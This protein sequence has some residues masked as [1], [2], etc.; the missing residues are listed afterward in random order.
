[1]SQSFI[2]KAEKQEKRYI[3][4]TLI[5][6]SGLFEID[7]PSSFIFDVNISSKFPYP[8]TSVI[9]LTVSGSP[10]EDPDG[11]VYSGQF[12]IRRNESTGIPA[13]TISGS[14]LNSFQISTIE[15]SMSVIESESSSGLDSIA[16]ITFN[17]IPISQVGA[18]YFDIT[19][20]YDDNVVPP[21]KTVIIPFLSFD[22]TNR[23]PFYSNP[24]IVSVNNNELV[25]DAG[26]IERESP[27]I[28]I[29]ENYASTRNIS[30]L[31]INFNPATDSFINLS[32]S[33][34]FNSPFRQEGIRII[35]SRI[36][37][38]P[39][40]DSDGFSTNANYNV[41]IL[42]N[43]W[44]TD[45]TVAGVI[46]RDNAQIRRLAYDIKYG[47]GSIEENDIK[48]ELMFSFGAYAGTS[49]DVSI[50]GT[51]NGSGF[52]ITG[53][54]SVTVNDSTSTSTSRKAFVITNRHTDPFT[55][56][57]LNIDKNNFLNNSLII[58]G[59]INGIPAS[60]NISGFVNNLSIQEFINQIQDKLKSTYPIWYNDPKSPVRG[61]VFNI[62]EKYKYG[63]V[64]DL[65]NI[66]ITTPIYPN[67]IINN[68]LVPSGMGTTTTNTLTFFD[69][70][71]TSS[72]FQDV[73]D[74]LR[75]NLGSYGFVFTWN[76][77]NVTEWRSLKFCPV[78]FN[79]STIQQNIYSSG[80]IKTLNLYSNIDCFFKIS[81]DSS[82]G[83]EINYS[84]PVSD[85][86]DGSNAIFF[87]FTNESLTSFSEY[88]A[89]KINY[90]ILHN[91]VEYVGNPSLLSVSCSVSD[92]YASLSYSYLYS[93]VAPAPIAP[94]VYSDYKFISPNQI[95]DPD[96]FVW[97]YYY[98]PFNL[99]NSSDKSLGNSLAGNFSKLSLN[100]TLSEDI[101][102]PIDQSGTLGDLIDYINSPTGNNKYLI[103]AKLI[104]DSF[105][106]ILQN[107]INPI[108]YWDIISKGSLYITSKVND[109]TIRRYSFDRYITLDSL[110]SAIQEDWLTNIE[111]TIDPATGQRAD[112]IPSSLISGVFEDITSSPLPK[113]FGGKVNSVFIPVVP[114]NNI[115]LQM[116]ILFVDDGDPV[117][118]SPGNTE[119][120]PSAGNGIQLALG[121][122]EKNGILFLNKTPNSFFEP[123]HSISSPIAFTT[124]DADIIYL[125]L[126]TRKGIKNSTYTSV[127]SNYSGI[128][129]YSNGS[130]P[131]NIIPYI[132]TE[133]R[134][135]NAWNQGSPLNVPTVVAIPAFA[136]SMNITI[137]DKGILDT[138]NINIINKTAELDQFGF[139]A[140]NRTNNTKSQTKSKVGRVFGLVLDNRGSWDVLISPEAILT[141]SSSGVF[142]H[143]GS[144]YKRDIFDDDEGF[145]FTITTD[146]PEDIKNS[147][148]ITPLTNNPQ[149]WVLRI[150][151]G[152]KNYLGNIRS[153]ITDQESLI[154]CSINVDFLV[155]GR[156]TG[157]QGTARVTI[158][159]D[160]TC[161]YDIGL[162]D[163]FWNL[164]DPPKPAGP[165]IIQ[166]RL[167]LS[168]K[169]LVDCNN[170]TTQIGDNIAINSPVLISISNIPTFQNGN[171]LLLLKSTYTPEIQGFY[172]PTG[173]EI[174]SIQ[175]ADC[176]AINLNI[177]LV[178]RLNKEF[179]FLPNQEDPI[180]DSSQI[181]SL[182]DS[183]DSY[184]LVRPM[185]QFPS[186]DIIRDCD[187]SEVV[188]VGIGYTFKN[189][190]NGARQDDVLIGVNLLFPQGVYA[191]PEMN[192]CYRYYYNQK[193]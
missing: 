72:S 68:Y 143:L 8:E 176:S 117:I 37:S 87:E 141:Y 16:K 76:I 62:D 40:K 103:K 6:D 12:R 18:K 118:T 47:I 45:S 79:G 71:G 58:E 21:V 48:P 189:W 115:K 156:T 52:P 165:E 31:S 185:F 136:T 50:T 14:G 155:T 30:S 91:Y 4:E 84:N 180:S 131:Y 132:P 125:L 151:H 121:G 135:T 161:V 26:A 17:L 133:S 138:I 146:L 147:I 25:I 168:Y 166:N 173:N 82:K 32:Y 163:Y 190:S 23:G 122:Y 170:L 167:E 66:N 34:N 145:D 89:S 179:L 157:V 187:P 63:N 99:E 172:Y 149:V 164:I 158:Y 74:W 112:A 11:T 111:V 124:T 160:Y 169:N 114:T 92:Y 86:F 108:N 144:F 78:I 159:Y 110:V 95:Q 90:V 22:A 33:D 77:P 154:G 119:G 73:Y 174:D 9:D 113:T 38:L 60:L 181:N 140:V 7:N 178:Q 134:F 188:I 70:S 148:S 130:I 15:N 49:V 102:I 54:M 69:F 1:M 139:L 116:G 193:E 27:V 64:G 137:E 120:D 128:I 97:R 109:Q 80:Q 20:P 28:T 46:H 152:V 171:A 182:L 142:S 75:Y 56:F 41:R 81:K 183:S 192:L 123:V 129:K 186:Y 105:F 35:P 3:G 2:V 57:Y 51:V 10:G 85:S 101:H 55:K 175:F 107:N 88:I 127:T 5:Y 24:I 153:Q 44:K 100:G 19:I 36:T 59:Y 94:N 13:I 177:P 126:R 67:A 43:L 61:L 53:S 65:S 106:D 83:Q 162:C 96:S 39:S 42:T 104:D 93:S 191:S 29:E 98:Q 150:E 184:L